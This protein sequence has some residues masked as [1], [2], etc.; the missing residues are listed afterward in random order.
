MSDILQQN[1]LFGFVLF[2]NHH[3][4][5]WNIWE[6]TKPGNE[7][8]E[9]SHDGFW[10]MAD[11]VASERRIRIGLEI[12]AKHFE[13]VNSTILQDHYYSHFTDEKS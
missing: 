11:S 12:Q 9:E 1:H 5:T 7:K 6:C 4:K 8:P 3:P 10:Q 2:C 13:H